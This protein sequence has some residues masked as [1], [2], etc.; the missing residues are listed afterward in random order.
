MV[1]GAHE[2]EGAPV[3]P[4]SNL[5]GETRDEPADEPTASV[6][7]AE[8]PDND[9]GTIEING[10]T[11]SREE[12]EGYVNDGKGMKPVLTKKT[13]EFSEATKR[14]EEQ[15]EMQRVRLEELEDRLTAPNEVD[16]EMDFA[17]RL[18]RD[19]EEIKGSIRED[20]DVRN[21]ELKNLARENEM[22]AAVESMSNRAYCK[23][24]ELRNYMEANGLGP[25]QADL[26]YRAL[27]GGLLG[28]ALGERSAMARGAGAPAPMGAGNSSISPTFTT[29]HEA[30]GVMQSIEDM[31]WDDLQRAAQADAGIPKHRS[32]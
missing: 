5:M 29:P 16:E 14:Y 3:A 18:Q 32:G 6:P 1:Y 31:S 15:L 22:E 28:Q 11:Y 30:P 8:A 17:S 2:G 20:R 27:Y 10:T 24:S 7:A 4:E 13:Q 26:A 12:L 19:I 9:F 21:R 25:A 23:P